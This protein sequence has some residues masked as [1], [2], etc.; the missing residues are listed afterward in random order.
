MFF[1]FFSFIALDDLLQ[2]QLVQNAIHMGFSLSEIRS[3]ME[4]KLHLSGESYTSV[5]DLV[6]DLI[7]AQ[8]E[9]IKGEPPK[10][11][12]L[13]QGELSKLWNLCVYFHNNLFLYEVYPIIIYS[14]CPLTQVLLNMKL[15]C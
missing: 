15:R 12:P 5:E 10:E 3:I 8:K 14:F 4:K 13:E 7:S 9:N 6:A 11:S 1:F 2:N